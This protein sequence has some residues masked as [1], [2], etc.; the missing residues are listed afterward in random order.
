MLPG[1]ESSEIPRWSSQ[2]DQSPFRL[3]MCTNSASLN[4][5][6]TVPLLQMDWYSKVSLLTISGPPDLN[7]SGGRPSG[8]GT[9]PDDIWLIARRTSLLSG[10][11]IRSW[12]ASQTGS[13]DS[14]VGSKVDVWLRTPWKCSAQRERMLTRSVISVLLSFERTGMLPVSL[15]QYTALRPS[16]KD[17]VVTVCCAELLQTTRS[18]SFVW[19][20]FEQHC[21]LGCTRISWLYCSYHSSVDTHTHTHTQTH[22]CN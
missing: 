10:G 22:T 9:L 7:S 21:V 8:H 1:M 16:Q 19:V 18:L 5:C 13:S 3:K 14:T 12:F 15:G 2:T 4:S 11:C 17:H 6:G 20:F